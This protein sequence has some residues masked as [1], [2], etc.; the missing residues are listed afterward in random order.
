MSKRKIFFRWLLYWYDRLR[1][2]RHWR[3]VWP[4]NEW[5][6]EWSEYHVAK[7]LAL[8]EGITRSRGT[9]HIEYQRRPSKERTKLDER[10]YLNREDW[11]TCNATHTCEGH[12]A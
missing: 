1:G 8:D 5:V 6:S 2:A 4:H 9:A 7:F 12:R 3:T 11:C 10:R